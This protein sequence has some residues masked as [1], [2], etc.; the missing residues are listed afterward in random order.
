MSNH[1]NCNH[2]DDHRNGNELHTFVEINTDRDKEYHVVLA[3]FVSDVG[4]KLFGG[5]IG[6]GNDDDEILVHTYSI[7]A[8]DMA[9]AISKARDVD[10]AR[11]MEQITGFAN[12]IAEGI[13]EDWVKDKQ[14]PFTPEII[15]DFRN[16]MLKEGNFQSFFFAEP[17]TM[18]AV[19]ASNRGIAEKQSESNILRDKLNISDDVE[20]WLKDN[21]NQEDTSN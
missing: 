2:E 7:M 3:Y 21:D 14:I 9:S 10:Y 15:E 8:P 20:S 12:I 17:T 18:T 5:S 19:L 4:M 16:Y 13:E 11:K 6:F 1:E